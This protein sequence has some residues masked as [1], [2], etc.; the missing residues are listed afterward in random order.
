MYIRLYLHDGLRSNVRC[1][2][3]MFFCLC[4]CTCAGQSGTAIH[5]RS[6]SLAAISLNSLY[7]ANRVLVTQFCLLCSTEWHCTQLLYVIVASWKFYI[8]DS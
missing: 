8:F 7:L 6:Y 3:C 1:I 2:T 5:I 4:T